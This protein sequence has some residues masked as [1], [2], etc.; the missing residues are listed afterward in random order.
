MKCKTCGE[1]FD[2][3]RFP[4]CPFCMTKPE[5]ES[6]SFKEHSTQAIE[7]ISSEDGVVYVDEN[8]ISEDE[9][10]CS[11]IQIDLRSGINENNFNLVNAEVDDNL[12]VFEQVVENE[13]SYENGEDSLE[14]QKIVK[15]KIDDVYSSSYKLFLR[16]CKRNNLLYMEELTDEFFDGLESIKGFG[17]KSISKLKVV[18]AG[19]NPEIFLDNSSSS[20]SASEVHRIYCVGEKIEALSVDSLKMLGVSLCTVNDLKNHNI[21]TLTELS[22]VRIGHLEAV[23]K[24]SAFKEILDAENLLNES[25]T[26][27]FE[28]VLSEM[29][30]SDNYI[31]LLYRAEGF[32]LQ[33]T[34][35][36]I[37][38]TR[39]RVRQIV[40]KM[41]LRI[42]GLARCVVDEIKSNNDFIYV[43]EILDSFENDDLDVYYCIF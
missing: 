11:A 2:L 24:G 10:A 22:N 26:K 37:G 43:Q 19:Y 5:I 16:H 32:T 12:E 20:D 7:S 25:P 9:V 4:V 17:A 41:K 15:T 29:E 30:T 27:I 31:A 13:L 33:E 8:D 28:N 36:D 6:D 34:G 38:K 42:S 14:T 40:N 21:Y 1:E 39:E 3:E 18:Y 23:L 35:D